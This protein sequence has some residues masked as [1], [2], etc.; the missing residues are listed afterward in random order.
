MAK[1]II[2]DREFELKEGDAIMDACM[3]AGIPFGCQSGI[4]GTCIIEVLEGMEHLSER[5][6]Q[7]T[8]MELEEHERLACQCRILS[9][10]VKVRQ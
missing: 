7:E 4:C 6:Q 5:N 3:E 9:G 2:D 1:L 10:T 8:D